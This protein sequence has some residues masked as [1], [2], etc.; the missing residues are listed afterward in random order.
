[1]VG[2]LAE[3]FR[4]VL[5]S[6][7]LPVTLISNFSPSIFQALSGVLRLHTVFDTTLRKNGDFGPSTLLKHR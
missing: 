2:G 4:S 3:A 7:D 5:R 6:S 1:M